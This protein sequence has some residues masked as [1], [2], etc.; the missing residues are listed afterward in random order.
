MF[1][2]KEMFKI[3]VF[4]QL[5]KLLVLYTLSYNLIQA[6]FKFLKISNKRDEY[7]SN[8]HGFV[9]LFIFLGFFFVILHI[10]K[11]KPTFLSKQFAIEKNYNSINDVKQTNKQPQTEAKK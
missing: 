9:Q 4:I 2:K 11:K 6:N 10:R 1:V 8:V 3:N 7:S 5:L